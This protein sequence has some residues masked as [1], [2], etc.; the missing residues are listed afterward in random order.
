MKPINIL[1]WRDTRI[2]PG[3]VD[4]RWQWRLNENTMNTRI[5]VEIA[6]QRQQLDFAGR[7]SQ[8]ARRRLNPEPL[9]GFLLHP[10]IDLRGRII[11][12][13]DK[14]QAWLDSSRLELGNALGSFG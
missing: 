2:N 11:S 9:A 10:N 5:V 7:F 4:V 14:R 13:P 8:L 3:C 6:Q 12:N 1:G